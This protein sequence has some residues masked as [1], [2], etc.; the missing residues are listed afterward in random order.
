MTEEHIC[1]TCKWFAEFEGVCCNGESE[2]RAAFMRQ[3]D[4]GCEKWE[5]RE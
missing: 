2:N 4:D 3:E 5:R 1:W